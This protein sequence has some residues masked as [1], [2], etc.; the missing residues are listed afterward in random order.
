MNEPLS[1]LPPY[2]PLPSDSPPP[3][4]PWWRSWKIIALIAGVVVL[5][6]AGGAGA[7]WLVNSQELP[8]EEVLRRS[9]EKDTAIQSYHRKYIVVLRLTGEKKL[10]LTGVTMSGEGDANMQDESNIKDQSTHQLK[11]EFAPDSPAV[12]MYGISSAEIAF[13]TRVAS[14]DKFYIRF[15]QLPT[16]SF[17]S[18]KPFENQWILFGSD[19]AALP[20]G[21]SGIPQQKV[22]EAS[23][24][25]RA[26]L[27][28][29][30]STEATYEGIQSLG[31]EK[32]EENNVNTYHLRWNVTP[33]TVMRILGSVLKEITPTIG[34]E[35]E[36][37]LRETIQKGMDQY[38][39]KLPVD[40][41]VGAKDFITY[42]T[43]LNA[44][45]PIQDVLLTVQATEWASKF[46]EPFE[47]SEPSDAK[48]P[49]ELMGS[50][51]GGVGFSS[52]STAADGDFDGLPDDQEALRSTNPANAD[53]DGDTLT[54]GDEVNQYN[55]DPLKP[56]SDGDGLTDADEALK[57]K[58]DPARADTDNDG[59]T[60]RQE[61]KNGYNPAG[62]GKMTPEQKKLLQ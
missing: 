59:Y 23:G 4:L 34:V 19:G 16:I 32:M 50:V 35:Q 1:P 31:I 8:V 47:V 25:A 46:N 45:V 60:D 12:K 14:N 13:E 49:E 39:N 27:Q 7:W 18:L 43:A 9:L 10:G 30:F 54:D 61:I 57:W 36:A 24:K 2:S 6:S 52:L 33:Q 5:L 48:T 29:V 62:E 21:I 37:Q 38:F 58:T 3:L 22:S 17:F 28:K 20:E 40:Y 26:A 15:T 53:T 42:K 51:L 55:T 56:D 44:S 41:W 11:I